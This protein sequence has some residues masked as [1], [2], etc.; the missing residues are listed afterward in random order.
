MNKSKILII[1]LITMLLFIVFMS[2]QVLASSVGTEFEGLSNENFAKITL[3]A[4]GEVEDNID[5][6]I[7]QNEDENNQGNETEDNQENETENN[8]ENE[9]EDLDPN[10]YIDLPQIIIN[11]KATI[12]TDEE[13]SNYTLYYQAIQISDIDFEQIEK[14]IDERSEYYKNSSEE[15]K[16]LK[17]EVEELRTDYNEKNVQDPSSDETLQAYQLLQTKIDNYNTRVGEINQKLQQYVTD[18]NNMLPDYDNTKWI[19]TENGEID[20]QKSG[21]TVNSSQT[22]HFILWARLDVGQDTYYRNQIYSTEIKVDGDGNNSVANNNVNGNTANSTNNNISNNN[23][24]NVSNNAVD[25]TVAN[26]DLPKTGQASMVIFIL[27]ALVI[28]IIAYLRYRKYDD[29]K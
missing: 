29:V 22:I 14:I 21:I 24:K 13:V 19:E 11:G 18:Y 16:Q 5:E 27:V 23:N 10:D 8:Q 20:V 28:S 25:N 15:L 4:D 9:T 6:F 7:N 26:R 17:A 2:G 12:K 3:G 1:Y